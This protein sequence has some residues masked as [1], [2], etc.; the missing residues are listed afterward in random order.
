MCF[1]LVKSCVVLTFVCCTSQ[2]D[3]YPDTDSDSDYDMYVGQGGTVAVP[4]RVQHLDGDKKRQW[5][6]DVL[7][8]S[9]TA[10]MQAMCR[11]LESV[12]KDPKRA[13]RPEDPAVRFVVWGVESMD[14]FSRICASFVSL[15]DFCI[16]HSLS[17]EHT[18]S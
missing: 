12:R 18:V 5:A 6:V 8:E 9:D 1:I 15:C 17:S 7:R 4:K 3:D 11:H 10:R 16:L 13:Q 14:L 2:P